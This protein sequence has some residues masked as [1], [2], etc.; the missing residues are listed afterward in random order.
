ME[1]KE[2]RKSVTCSL[3]SWDALL[4]YGVQF[5]VGVFEASLVSLRLSPDLLQIHFL[6]L[7]LHQGLHIHQHY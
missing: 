3:T 5:C 2:R 1:G 6:T 7:Q 4:A